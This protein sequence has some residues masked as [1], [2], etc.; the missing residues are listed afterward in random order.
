MCRAKMERFHIHANMQLNFEIFDVISQALRSL[1]KCF[2]MG[3]A[4]L[5]EKYA[6]KRGLSV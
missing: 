3:Y 2:A 1:E 4:R 5:L 6:I